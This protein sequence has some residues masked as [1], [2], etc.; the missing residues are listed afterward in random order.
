MMYVNYSNDSIFVFAINYRKSTKRGYI[1][2]NYLKKSESNCS[3]YESF[4]Y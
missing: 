1:K 4:D 3:S 2:V